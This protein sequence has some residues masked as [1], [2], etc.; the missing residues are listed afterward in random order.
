M[1]GPFQP[2]GMGAQAPAGAFNPAPWTQPGHESSGSY[3]FG[4][5]QAAPAPGA[6][7]GLMPPGGLDSGFSRLPFNQDA[8]NAQLLQQPIAQ[9]YP[10]GGVI[11]PAAGTDVAPA[12]KKGSRASLVIVCFLVLILAAAVTFS[13]LRFR[14]QLGF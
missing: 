4:N 14:P 13:V 1:A 11:A 12:R 10:V 7:P 3:A 8:G 9:P 6:L 2:L 5:A